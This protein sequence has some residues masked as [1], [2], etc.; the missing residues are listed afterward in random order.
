[1]PQKEWFVPGDGIA[2]EVISADIQQY[3]GPPATV[4]L[5]F[6]TGEYE[7][8]S[9]YWYTANSMM[10]AGM[11]E[12]LKLDSQ[13]WWQKHPPVQPRPFIE[14]RRGK[15]YLGAILPL[16]TDVSCSS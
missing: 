8:R 7:G 3:L 16:I 6:G 2:H 10:T 1:M 5:G 9:G 13:R 4:R 15:A 11:I 12:N 14:G